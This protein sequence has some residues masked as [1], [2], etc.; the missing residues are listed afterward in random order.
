MWPLIRFTVVHDN[1]QVSCRL[2]K[3]QVSAVSL[4]R[5]WLGKIGNSK[6]EN[7]NIGNGKIKNDKIGNGKIGNGN[8]TGK[9]HFA[10]I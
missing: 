2:A 3:H 10:N 7:G 1:L 8:K 9:V 6:I 4:K 5:V